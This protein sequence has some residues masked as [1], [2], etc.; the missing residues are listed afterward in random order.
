MMRI[1]DPVVRDV[2]RNL[3]Q[4]KA[5]FYETPK[6]NCYLST[7]AACKEVTESFAMSQIRGKRNGVQPVTV[8]G[9][10]FGEFVVTRWS[11]SGNYYEQ[12]K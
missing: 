6:I 9:Q 3:P 12:Y 7:Y 1:E 4:L 2:D 8:V 5:V 10:E 11:R